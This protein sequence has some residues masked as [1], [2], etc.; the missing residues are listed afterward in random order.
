MSYTGFG[1]TV[2]AVQACDGSSAPRH[3]HVRTAFSETYHGMR[4]ARRQG[5]ARGRTHWT[6]AKPESL[7]PMSMLGSPMMP[8]P[9]N[10]SLG[11][12]VAGVAWTLI[13]AAATACWQ[14]FTTAQR[15]RPV[16]QELRGSSHAVMRELP[17]CYRLFHAMT[18][19]AW[20]ERAS[21]RQR[22][23]QDF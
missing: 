21:L 14:P 22:H 6:Q 11:R 5:Q 9:S 12:I 15:L 10:A 23:L 3:S 7:R 20:S 2:D 1:R 17:F 13:A 18:K 4:A 8:R 19:A 16:V